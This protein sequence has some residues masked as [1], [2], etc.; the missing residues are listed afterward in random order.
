MKIYNIKVKLRACCCNISWII[1]TFIVY[2]CHKQY[3]VPCG[4]TVWFLSCLESDISIL[5]MQNLDGLCQ[6]FLW[7]LIFNYSSV[8]LCCRL[9]KYNYRALAWVSDIS[10]VCFRVCRACFTNSQSCLVALSL[11]QITQLNLKR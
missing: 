9:S 8:Y 7:D 11:I 6:R 5:V 1:M 2:S 4:W 10:S 3:M